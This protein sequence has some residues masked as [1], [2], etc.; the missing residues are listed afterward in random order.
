MIKDKSNDPSVEELVERA[1]AGHHAPDSAFVAGFRELA[2]SVQGVLKTHPRYAEAGILQRLAEP[3]R[4]ISFR[5][6]WVDDANRVQVNRGYRV[7]HSNALG[8]YKG[9]LRFRASVQEDILRRLAFEQTFK[10]ALTGLPMGGAKGG[11]DFDPKG[12]S[13][14]EIMRFCQAFIN[15]LYRDIGPY[16]DIP[17]GDIG[18][19][20]REIG[21]MFGRFKRLTGTF[22]GALTGK[23]LEFGGSCLRREATGYGVIH[24]LEAM[25]S[26]RGEEVDSRRAVVSGAGNVAA[27]A[28]KRLANTGCQVV[29]LSDSKG[30]LHCEQGFTEGQIDA[31]IA[32][33]S[34]PDFKLENHARRV[35]GT[36]HKGKTPWGVACD[37]AVPCATQ[38]E[39]D[40]EAARTLVDNGCGIL[41]EG[42]NLPLTPEAR[43]IVQEAGMLYG[44]GKA[45]NIGGVAMS[46]LELSQNAARLHW[47]EEDLA[48]ALH[49][50][51]EEAHE[52][53]VAQGGDGRT[54]DYELGA[55]RAGFL[56][57]AS[58]MEAFGVD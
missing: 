22:S 19:G 11:A 51:M 45:A 2:T 9:G 43:K 46:G 26:H 27:H 55:N 53:C 49:R 39:V 3:D 48:Q 58:A 50:I 6:A 7:Q 29:T 18:V 21:F 41:V 36:W 16:R 37:I 57:V 15:E 31:I 13:E 10:N 28:A 47:A 1:C 14:G 23:G 33:H 52:E 54:P 8:P 40:A 25:L 4:V 32:E 35:D 56:K 12:R 34:D 30:F 24:F 42:A 38:N 17:A 44:P 5:V 20:E